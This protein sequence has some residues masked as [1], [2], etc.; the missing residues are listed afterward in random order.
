MLHVRHARSN[1]S[2][3]SS[4]KQQRENY[5]NSGFD[6]NFWKQQSTINFSIYFN[7][8]SSREAVALQLKSC[9]SLYFG[10]G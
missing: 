2:V 8:A 6:D 1:N 4:A 9:I 10:Y 5:H 3:R 7:G